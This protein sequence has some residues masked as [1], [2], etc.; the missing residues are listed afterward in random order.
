MKQNEFV[1]LELFVDAIDSTDLITVYNYS[2]KIILKYRI[3]NLNKIQLLEYKSI[4]PSKKSKI[5][6][7]AIPFYLGLIL[8]CSLFAI[9]LYSAVNSIINPKITIDH[10]ITYP[11]T[12]E[13]IKDFKA[14]KDKVI[15]LN[16]D[17]KVIDTLT[18]EEMKSS[19]NLSPKL[20]Y[21][22]NN[23]LLLVGCV[24]GVSFF[25]FGIYAF[26]KETIGEIK[27]NKILNI[28]KST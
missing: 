10:E 26:T 4:K 7:K 2:R 8:F 5:I 20:T 27:M 14:F 11:I 21:E 23:F 13:Q 28:M 9:G 3:A 25:L 17:K 22:K 18:V 6:T 1:T 16:M 12:G 19:I 24:F 15:L